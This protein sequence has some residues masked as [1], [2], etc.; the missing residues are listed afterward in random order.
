[1]RMWVLW[2]C[3]SATEETM[4]LPPLMLPSIIGMIVSLL[5][6]AIHSNSIQN[7]IE[8]LFCV[9]FIVHMYMYVHN[10]LWI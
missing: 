3:V 6:H 10:Y 1:M 2:N 4:Y 8:L 7:Y 5:F 9:G